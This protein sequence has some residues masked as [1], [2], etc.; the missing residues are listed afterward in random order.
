MSPDRVNLA[1]RPFRNTR[2]VARVTV[3]LWAVGLGLL[4]LNISRYLDYYSGTSDEA[5]QRLDLVER[6]IAQER[7]Q[8]GQLDSRLARLDL[9]RQNLEVAF[10]NQQIAERAFSWSRLFDDLGEV[11]PRNVRLQRLTPR[12]SIRSGEGDVAS[13]RVVL[14]LDG[15]ARSDEDVLELVD[16]LFA[17]QSFRNPNLTREARRPQGTV[18]IME[19]TYLPEGGS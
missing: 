19:V 11:L 17:H 6:G 9:E 12:V 4:A 2:P 16:A 10:L 15:T 18:F 7:D 13:D 1:G 14:D 8:S 5:L 3:L